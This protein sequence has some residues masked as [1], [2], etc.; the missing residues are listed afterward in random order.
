MRSYLVRDGHVATETKF[1]SDDVRSCP[2]YLIQECR[3]P[4]GPP[5]SL[6]D[7]VLQK[8][9]A[10]HEPRPPVVL[11]RPSHHQTLLLQAALTRRDC[12]SRQGPLFARPALLGPTPAWLVRARREGERG[13]GSA[14]SSR[15]GAMQ[16][17]CW[18]RV[19]QKVMGRVLDVREARWICF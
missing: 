13:R 17:S 14:W 1:E 4:H 16:G 11:R 6:V 15:P 2:T 7:R 19:I 8:I 18:P 5:R 9:S 12:P 10:C 3:Q